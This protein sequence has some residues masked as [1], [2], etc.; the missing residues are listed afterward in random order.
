MFAIKVYTG[1]KESDWFLL[2]DT[3]DYVVYCWSIRE[4]AEAV[5][6]QLDYEKCEITEDIPSTA[7]RR[8]NERRDA[9]K[10]EENKPG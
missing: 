10:I 4:E 3:S 9:L 7:L 2:R 5:L 8:F 6:K 1:K